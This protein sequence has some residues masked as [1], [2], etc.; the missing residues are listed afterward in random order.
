[1]IKRLMLF[2]F[3]VCRI[4]TYSQ[5]IISEVPKENQLIRK[6]V[7]AIT[8]VPGKLT[9]EEVLKSVDFIPVKEDVPNFG[10]TPATVWLKIELIN[11]TEIE[12]LE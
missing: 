5:T 3:V 7:Y 9:I 6:G 8:D 4:L 11:K 2:V 12:K 10:I 1:M